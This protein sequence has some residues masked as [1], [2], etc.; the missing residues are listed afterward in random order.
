MQASRVLPLGAF[1]LLGVV[2][3]AS[4]QSIY[5]GDA[6]RYPGFP[7]NPQTNAVVNQG[8]GAVKPLGPGQDRN[9]SGIG[10][11]ATSA[12]SAAAQPEDLV[13]TP[14]PRRIQHAIKHHTPAQHG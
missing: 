14:A 12:P 5:E 13:G 1:V 3:M 4:A 8:S 6:T 2:T 10:G 11:S 9:T 7:N